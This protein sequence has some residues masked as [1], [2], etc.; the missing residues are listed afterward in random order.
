[1]VTV[2]KAVIARI[3]K[4]GKKFEIL[5][6]PELAQKVKAGKGTDIRDILA[7]QDVFEDQRKGIR[8]SKKDLEFAFGTADVL[9]AAEIILREG[10]VHTTAEQRTKEQQDKWDKIV[11]TIAMNAIDPK[12]NIPIP[13]KTIADALEQAYF[14]IDTR[15]VEDQLPDAIKKL[16]GILPFSFKEKSLQVINVPASVA[17]RVSDICKKLAAVKDEKWNSDGSLTAT[18][19]VPAGLREE[20][21]DKINEVT[22]GKVEI[23]L[24]D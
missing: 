24:L 8:A 4:A 6:D 3:N 5:V 19:V 2:D 10:R 20:L 15:K 14:R 12:R 16:R 18:V 23:K 1:M 21:M 17:R 22:R 9:Q 7:V 13:Q 11:A